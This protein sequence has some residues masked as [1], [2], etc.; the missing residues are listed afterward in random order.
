MKKLITLFL[1]TALSIGLLAVGASADGD[2]IKIGT[3]EIDGVLDEAY[4]YSLVLK[5]LGTA[6]NAYESEWPGDCTADVYFLYDDDMV[7]ICAV[8]N[9]N[10]VLSK[11]EDYVL[12]TYNPIQNDVIEFRVSLNG[13]LDTIKVAVDAYGYGMF[14]LTDHM[15]KFDYSY[16]EYA[17][18]HTDTQY[19]VEVGIPCTEDGF[20]MIEAGKFGFAYQIND[21]DD[22]DGYYYYTSTFA[23]EEPKTPIFYELSDE[24]AAAPVVET[25]AADTTVDSTETVATAPATFDAALVAMAI[26]VVSGAAYVITSKKH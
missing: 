10:D 13:E 12:N 8:V 6:A 1:T 21:I 14:G 5:D 26:S 15:E 17:T 23:G 20:D 7:Y 9:D 22:G 4:T 18:T 2:K 24:I 19:I 16:I 3:P 11:G 25:V